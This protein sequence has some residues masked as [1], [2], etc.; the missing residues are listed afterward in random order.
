MTCAEGTEDSIVQIAGRVGGAGGI[1]M[2]P[3]HEK[4]EGAWT[5]T[6]EEGAVQ[7]QV[8]QVSRETLIS[9]RE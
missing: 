9:K 1:R 3:Q 7:A 5:G 6:R 2:P 8:V 4:F